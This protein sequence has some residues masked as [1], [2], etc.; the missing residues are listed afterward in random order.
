MCSV[1]FARRVFWGGIPVARSVSQGCF[2]RNFSW[3]Y[4]LGG[5]LSW[6]PFCMASVAMGVFPY[7][8]VYGMDLGNLTMSMC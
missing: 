8:C 7:V 4:L 5:R 3:P 1:L 2:T 6:G